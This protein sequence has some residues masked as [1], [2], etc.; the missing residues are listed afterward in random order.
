MHCNL[1]ERKEGRC[2]FNP[3]KSDESPP[4]EVDCL[5]NADH[6]AEPPRSSPTTRSR[7]LAPIPLL[8]RLS[9]DKKHRRHPDVLA[10]YLSSSSKYHEEIEPMA[11]FALITSM[12][13]FGAL[14][15]VP[16]KCLAEARRSSSLPSVPLRVSPYCKTLLARSSPVV[17][18][19]RK[20]SRA[21]GKVCWK[22]GRTAS[23][24][25]IS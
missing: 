20:T 5:L 10:I 11:I 21:S 24:L 17:H 15:L 16:P 6:A 18:Q 3:T 22:I 25:F 7:P 12:K 8:C 4:I 13:R 14:P 9:A 23:F 2:I 1:D 19:L